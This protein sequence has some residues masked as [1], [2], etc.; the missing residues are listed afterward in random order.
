VFKSCTKKYSDESD[1]NA[2]CFSFYCDICGV[3]YKSAP[4]HFTGCDPPD[5]TTE[6]E[7]WTMMWKR[8]H[9]LAFERANFEASLHF[10]V[11]PGCDLRVCDKCIVWK[12]DEYG[13]MV[14]RRC[15][16]CEER[17][18]RLAA[19]KPALRYVYEPPE[20]APPKDKLRK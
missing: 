13:D 1:K 12:T 10:Y 6:I 14:R 9:A 4:I 18:S 5:T 16:K 15:I 17:V 20:R 3:T 19:V 7:L 8:E 2:Y 11:C